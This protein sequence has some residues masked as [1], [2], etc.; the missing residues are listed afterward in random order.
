MN[1]THRTR[2]MRVT[3]ALLAASSPALAHP[4]DHHAESIL[5]AVAHWL[6]SPFHLA[7]GTGV[8]ALFA[9]ARVVRRQRVRRQEQH[10]R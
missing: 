5:S 2:N 9:I 1:T 7:I 8:L 10:K 6:T 3:A 4:G